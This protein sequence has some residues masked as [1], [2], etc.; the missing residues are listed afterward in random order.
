M[1]PMSL[2]FGKAV[3]V[4]WTRSSLTGLLLFSVIKMEELIPVLHGALFSHS[5]VNAPGPGHSVYQAF[6]GKSHGACV[7]FDRKLTSGL[8]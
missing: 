4:S 2:H 6:P 8:S 1:S 7:H 5:G 3:G